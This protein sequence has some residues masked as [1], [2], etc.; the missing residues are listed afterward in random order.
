MEFFI[1]NLVMNPASA[2]T[3]LT[4]QRQNQR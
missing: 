2:S 1:E 3:P 4:E